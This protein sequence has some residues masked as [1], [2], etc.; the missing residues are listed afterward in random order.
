MHQPEPAS[1]PPSEATPIAQPI[2]QPSQ[3]STSRGQGSSQR[4]RTETRNSP[5]KR[6][7]SVEPVRGGRRGC[8]GSRG[9]SEGR[10]Q[11][12]ALGFS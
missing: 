12:E 10:F 11:V 7:R 8:V 3:G 6:R 1:V 2:P 9:P 5:V 4:G